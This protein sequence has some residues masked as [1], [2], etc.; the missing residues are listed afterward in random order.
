MY[1][2]NTYQSN[3]AK[4]M[5]IYFVLNSFYVRLNMVGKRTM[6]CSKYD[7]DIAS[8][9][10]YIKYSILELCSFLLCCFKSLK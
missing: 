9:I 6:I 8:I 2:S 1:V 7:G 4:V 5:R 3:I 10:E